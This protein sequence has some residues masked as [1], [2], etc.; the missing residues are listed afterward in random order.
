MK[1][2]DIKEKMKAVTEQLEEFAKQK[3]TYTKEFKSITT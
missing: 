2:D 3:K 1:R